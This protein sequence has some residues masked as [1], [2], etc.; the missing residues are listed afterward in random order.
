M[1]AIAPDT[2]ECVFYLYPTL[3]S[4]R[5]AEQIGGTGFF[6]AVELENNK[7]W[8]QV[9]AVTNRHCV[10]E[11]G[12]HLV[13]RVNKNGGQ[14]DFMETMANAWIQHPA[15]YDVAVLPLELSVQH[16]I[17]VIPRDWLVT[18]ELLGALSI[19]P[20]DDVFMVSRFLSQERRQKNLPMVRFGNISRM[21]GEPIPDK[22]GINQDSF[23]VEMRSMSGF[24][25]SPVFVYINPTLARP[26]NWFTPAMAVYSQQR[27]G[28]WLLGIDWCHLPAYDAVLGQDKKTP[29]EPKEWVQSNTGMA[30]VIPAWLLSDLLNSEQL[31]MQRKKDDEA[32]TADKNRS[33]VVLDS[34]DKPLTKGDFEKALREA[35]KN[36]S[37]FP[38]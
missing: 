17:R 18:E 6:V 2:L 21:H 35:S 26:P 12:S 5:N 31:V 27:H 32:I 22:Y 4:A 13:L 9:Y 7:A 34:A 16:Q 14:V 37:D 29:I 1:P 24:S 28:P 10:V 3:A 30:G 33:P 11:S 20:G 25:G 19:G 36:M 8:F 38:G 23:L 15:L